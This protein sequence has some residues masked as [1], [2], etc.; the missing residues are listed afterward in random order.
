MKIF[1]KTAKNYMEALWKFLAAIVII[2]AIVVFLRLS[3]D[4]PSIIRT[5]ISLAGVVLLG[6]GGWSVV[7]IH[8]FNLKQASVAGI[9][10]SFGIHW[11]LPVFHSAY[12]VM[13]LLLINTLVYSVIVFCG[14]WLA[15]KFEKHRG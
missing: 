14:A 11:T 9:L 7:R 8:R 2:M 4:F 13:Y 10:L 15:T 6:L 3:S 5:L 1:G 12:E